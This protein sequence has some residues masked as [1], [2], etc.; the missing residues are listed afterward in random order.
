MFSVFSGG[1]IQVAIGFAGG[2]GSFLT[3]RSGF[4]L[5]ACYVWIKWVPQLC[6][7]LEPP[8]DRRLRGG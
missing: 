6:G 3:K 2:S 5:K 4:L 7:C 1:L 8:D